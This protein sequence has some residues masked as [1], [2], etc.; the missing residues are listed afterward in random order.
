M[1]LPFGEFD[2][3]LK[4]DWLVKHRVSLDCATKRVVL[5]RTARERQNYLSNVTSALRAE[6]L[7]RKGCGAYLAYISVSDSKDSSVKDIRTVKDFSDV[8]PKELPGLPLNREV[9]FG[10]EL[11]PGTAPVFIAPL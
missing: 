1:E 11:L 9:E 2:L 4:M 5:R 7:V 6:K 10:L 8:F 3:I